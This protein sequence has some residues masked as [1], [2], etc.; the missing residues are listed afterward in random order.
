MGN[1]DELRRRAEAAL[2][3]APTDSERAAEEARRVLAHPDLGADVGVIAAHALGRAHHE[4]G[5]VADACEVLAHAAADA[6]RLGLDVREGH[7]RNSLGL[8]LFTSGDHVAAIREL[9]LA[10]SRL[11]GT[12]R[13]RVVM[14]RGII[15]IH[16]GR[17][18]AGL[19]RF[20]SV[21]DPLQSGDDHLSV[22]R[23]FVNRGVAH[24]LLGHLDAADRDFRQGRGQ[25]LDLGQ[26][27]LAASAEANI[28]FVQGRRGDIPEA[29]EWFERA[30]V[31]YAAI[32]EPL[33]YVAILDCDLCE[34]LLLAGLHSEA[35]DAA[36]RA[37]DT[38]QGGTNLVQEA[39]ARLLL[40]R[41]LRA[42]GDH[43]AAVEA[44]RSAREQFE[45]ADRSSWALQARFLELLATSATDA[46]PSTIVAE[47]QRIADELSAAG[48]SGE[49][50]R[51]RALAGRLLIEC[52]RIPAA[53]RQLTIAA[54]ARSRGTADG[55]AAAWHATALLRV[56]EGDRRGARRAVTAGLNVLERH[57]ATLG[58]TELRAGAAV[59]GLELA[60]LGVELALRDRR[61]RETL[62][63]V[64]RVRAVALR[65]PPVQPP[66]DAELARQ[67]DEFRHTGA[68]LRTA[69][70][71]GQPLE[72]LE[73]HQAALERRIRQQSR[74]A[75]GL[76][77]DGRDVL[78]VSRLQHVLGE[79][80]LIEYFEF[81]D[82]L[83]AIVA[84]RRRTTLRRLATAYE[85]AAEVD[86]VHFALRRLVTAVGGP[87][88]GAI[89]S[90]LRHASAR[91]DSLLLA[92]LGA[93]ATGE[94][95]VVPSPLVRSVPWSVLP[96]RHQ[97]V[98]VA[99]SAA[100]WLRPVRRL[101]PSPRT[102]V[103][104]GPGLPAASVEA[105][106]VRRLHPGS[107]LLDGGAATAAAT[108]DAA[109]RADLLHVAAH[110]TFRS[111]SP[112]FSSLQL[113]DGP[114][115]LYDFERLSAVPHTVVLSACDAATTR[116]PAGDEIIGTA[117]TLI[118]IGVRAVIAPLL[119]V[120]DVAV[121]DLMV[122]VHH[123]LRRGVTAPGAL[124]NATARQ[125]GR[126]GELDAAAFVCIGTDSGP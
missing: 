84:D 95:I 102:F 5:E 11:T 106:A 8:S 125:R 96:S 70:L 120:S 72:A 26:H 83:H 113:V 73:R 66:R 12:D 27:A 109:A 119:P 81:E 77:D 14:Q 19:A 90:G 60:R 58:A 76:G 13:A 41:S 17:L 116:V 97:P 88:S 92:P 101:T 107:T 121:G 21:L 105:R 54:A 18:D 50:A 46:E 86:A 23:L 75:R 89:V 62:Q 55:R 43:H 126:R 78:D 103:I 35:A 28:A 31:S 118:G 37:I 115:T 2:A 110:G 61:P 33:R 69:R 108:L 57:R 40:A 24:S 42:A 112:L 38:S 65:I 39:E 74:L 15:D 123:E 51:A 9:D 68:A 64:D 44:A 71:E 45:L 52:G 49:A 53:R 104:A 48:W 93:S 7:I 6:A 34:V 80:V 30:R 117:M 67:L 91:L 56:A 16:T 79:R 114:V 20:N 94:L 100:T 1:D 32:G 10:E 98:T 99:P 122:D 22:A 29:L 82:S 25:A 85:V 124:A 3:L 47:A 59:H 87:A 111:D 4:R 63:R 36:R